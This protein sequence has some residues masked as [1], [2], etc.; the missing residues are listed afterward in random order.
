MLE[1]SA[2]GLRSCMYCRSVSRPM[3]EMTGIPNC[4]RTSWTA[5]AAPELP[6]S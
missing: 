5:D 2:G 4:W 6:R 1:N 3:T